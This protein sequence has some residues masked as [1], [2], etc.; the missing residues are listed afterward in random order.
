[1]QLQP[2][3][4]TKQ[5]QVAADPE[6][7]MPVSALLIARI[8]ID[9]TVLTAIMAPVLVLTLYINPRIA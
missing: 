4:I 1:V 2:H 9:G 3:P 6:Y 7:R 8:L 5:P